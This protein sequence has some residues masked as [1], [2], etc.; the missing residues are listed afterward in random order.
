MNARGDGVPSAPIT[1]DENTERLPVHADVFTAL[2]TNKSPLLEI[3]IPYGLS[4]LRLHPPPRVP[5]ELSVTPGDR[6]CESPLPP[7]WLAEKRYTV[8]VDSS[9]IHAL[10]LPSKASPSRCANP[11]KA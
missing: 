9:A 6:F 7:S 5:V 11:E 1:P 10:P 2:A 8:S 4:M 3:A